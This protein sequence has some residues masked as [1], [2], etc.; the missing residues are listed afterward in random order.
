MPDITVSSTTDSQSEVNRVAGAAAAPEP[1][2]EEQAEQEEQQRQRVENGNYANEKIQRRFNKLTAQRSEA[3]RERDEER[4]HRASVERE[5]D[6]LR[7]RLAEIEGNAPL[8]RAL[9]A[10]YRAAELEQ[11][12]LAYE[13]QGT[14][15]QSP[16]EQVAPTEEPQQQQQAN[17]AIPPEHQAFLA[18]QEQHNKKLM[19]ILSKTPDGNEI[20]A[21]AA[22]V[23]E[24]MRPEISTAISYALQNSPNSEEVMFHLMK[25]SDLL[26]QANQLPPQ[27]AFAATLRLAGRLEAG[28]GQPRTVPVSHAPPPIKPLGHSGTA[29]VEQDPSQMSL[30][31]YRKWYDRNFTRGRR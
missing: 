6:D 7:Q 15:E 20:A 11:R 3:E 12:L 16:L 9:A 1:T 13:R 22:S 2:P 10:E 5:R 26:R 21:R 4:V 8:D 19:E 23:I 25:N 17:E 28:N 18:F 14:E 27:D 31:E 24:Q 30:P 29:T